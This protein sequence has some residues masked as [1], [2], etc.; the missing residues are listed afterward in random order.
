MTGMARTARC[1]VG[2]SFLAIVLSVAPA[3]S[4]SEP[5]PVARSSGQ[6]AAQTADPP[7]VTIAPAPRPNPC[8]DTVRAQRARW[9]ERGPRDYVFVLDDHRQVMGADMM[10]L[11]IV[12]SDGRVVSAKSLQYGGAPPLQHVPTIDTLFDRAEETAVFGGQNVPERFAAE[13][14]P[15]LGYVR[16]VDADGRDSIAD[17]ETFFQVNCFA[18]EPAG[19]APLPMTRAQCRNA[20]GTVLKS[21]SGDGCKGQGWSIGLISNAELCCRNYNAQGNDDLTAAQCHAAGGTERECA[22]DQ[23]VVGSSQAR[24]VGCCRKFMK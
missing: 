8:V 22:P 17:D 24:S 23:L 1:R 20:G 12:V 14:D 16:S 13:Y 19:C 4:Q 18:S 15:E 5:A 21:G 2:E 11:R 10:R 7:P 6:V 9:R 3:C